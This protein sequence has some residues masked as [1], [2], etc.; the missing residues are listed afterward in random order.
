MP[1]ACLVESN[2]RADAVSQGDE[3]TARVIV[4]HG[5]GVRTA[6]SA[7]GTSPKYD[8]SA[9]GFGRGRDLHASVAPSPLAP[10]GG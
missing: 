3:I 2:G 1:D 10:N 6:P 7:F 5:R 8:D 9:V 4:R